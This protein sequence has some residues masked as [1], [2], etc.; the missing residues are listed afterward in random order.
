MQIEAEVLTCIPRTERKQKREAV[1]LNGVNS[2]ARRQQ[3]SKEKWTSETERAERIRICLTAEKF[4]I[5]T[6]KTNIGAR[7][8]NNAHRWTPSLFWGDGGEALWLCFSLKKLMTNKK[9]C[10]I[11]WSILLA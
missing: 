9:N 6:V 1:K 4:N 2:H 11:S 8:T 10:T 3:Q 7:A 5:P